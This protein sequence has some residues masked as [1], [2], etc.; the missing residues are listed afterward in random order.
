MFP[1]GWFESILVPTSLISLALVSVAKWVLRG[2]S[3]D[4]AHNPPPFSSGLGTG[5]GGVEKLFLR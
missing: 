3:A 2:R 5:H 4:P 1:D